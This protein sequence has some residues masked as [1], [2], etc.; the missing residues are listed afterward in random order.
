VGA[1]NIYIY[2]YIYIYMYVCID[3][4]WL[5]VYARMLADVL[6]VHTYMHTYSLCEYRC[7]LPSS[8]AGKPAITCLK[9]LLH[10]LEEFPCVGSALVSCRFAPFTFSITV[11]AAV[12]TLV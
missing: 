4:V 1:T 11:V 7:T 12:A 3:H 10:L 5:Y 9:S 6:Y 2:I 8:H